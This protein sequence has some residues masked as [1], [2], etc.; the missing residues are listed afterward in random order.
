MKN[1]THPLCAVR[2]Y[3]ARLN[4]LWETLPLIKH[5]TK[6]IYP[7]GVE[8]GPFPVLLQDK[9]HCVGQLRGDDLKGP[10]SALFLP[11]LALQHTDNP[12]HLLWESKGPSTLQEQRVKSPFFLQNSK[13]KS[14]FKGPPKVLFFLWE[15]KPRKIQGCISTRECHLFS[16]SPLNSWL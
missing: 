2:I 13:K 14:S 9:L 6:G 3:K 15:A 12:S 10:S 11:A 5:L 8:V 7:S 4:A 1:F 16:Q